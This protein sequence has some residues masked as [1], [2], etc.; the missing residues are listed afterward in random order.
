M[1]ILCIN[2]AEIISGSIPL[3]T[4]GKVYEVIKING[5]QYYIEDNSGERRWYNDF[6]FK[7]IAEIRQ[8]KLEKL[9]I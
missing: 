5:S 8:E 9:G 3:L 1:R 2:N 4:T 7:D 6:R